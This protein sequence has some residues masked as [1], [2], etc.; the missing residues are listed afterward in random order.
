MY[1]KY[2][3]KI[4][5]MEFQSCK[6]AHSVCETFLTK[7]KKIEARSMCVNKCMISLCMCLFF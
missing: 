6:S 4:T 3:R 1:E 2:K 7:Q 5:V